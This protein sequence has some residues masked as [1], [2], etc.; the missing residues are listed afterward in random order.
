MQIDRSNQARCVASGGLFL[1][2]KA[3][4]EIHHTISLADDQGG[5]AGGGAASFAAIITQIVLLDIVFSVDSVITAVGLTSEFWIIVTAVVLSFIGILFYTGLPVET[6]AADIM[7]A[8]PLFCFP[9]DS[10]ESAID[11]MREKSCS[12]CF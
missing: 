6:A 10:L 8:P 11:M 3:V 12:K 4:R 2:F 7:V 9:D 5:T 1:I